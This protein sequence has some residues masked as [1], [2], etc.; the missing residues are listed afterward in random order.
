MGTGSPEGV[1]LME[2]WRCMECLK[3][4]RTVRVAERASSVGCS[5]CGGCDVDLVDDDE[6]ARLMKSRKEAENAMDKRASII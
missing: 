2:S 3:K 5:R 1:E 6:L 4:F